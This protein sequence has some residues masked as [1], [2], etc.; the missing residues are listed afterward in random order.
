M[1][2]QLISIGLVIIDFDNDVELKDNYEAQHEVS[3]ILADNAHSVYHFVLKLTYE[4]VSPAQFNCACFFYF[5][6][7]LSLLNTMVELA[8]LLLFFE[9][10]SI[11]FDIL[12]ICCP[13][14]LCLFDRI[15]VDYTFHH[16]GFIPDRRHCHSHHAGVLARW[17]HCYDIFFVDA[18]AI[19]VGHFAGT[20]Q[21]TH[22]GGAGYRF[23]WKDNRFWRL[24][25]ISR[26]G[27]L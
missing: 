23:Y 10:M 1:W 12:R 11:L 2:S 13:H 5:A 21:N 27:C 9:I 25:K 6:L 4:L 19:A 26:K 14:R 15:R 8:L 18:K 20:R 24:E 7:F 17:G 22:V 16:R 3:S